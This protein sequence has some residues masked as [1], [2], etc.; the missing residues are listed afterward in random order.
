MKV[1]DALDAALSTL[2]EKPAAVLPA[3]F[4]GYGA[5][6]VARTIPLVG[7]FVAYLL[8]LVQGRLAP[9]EAA[10]R[11][12][13]VEALEGTDP[14]SVDPE[15]LPTEQL[16]QAVSGLLTPGVVAVLGL[17]VLLGLVVWLVVG[18]AFHAGRIHTVH[19]ALRNR[20]PVRA[21]VSGAIRDVKPFVGLRLLEYGLYLL[22]TVVYGLVVF[23]AGAVYGADPGVGLVVAV[24]AAL[25]APLWLLALVAIAVV[26]VFA[27]QAV[28]VDRVGSI[29][30]LKRG[31]G[32][33]RRRPG[34][35]VVYVVIALG[36]ASAVTGVAAA[37]SALGVSQLGA[38]LSLLVVTPFLQLLKT[39]IYADRERI[40]AS[41][42][43]SGSDEGPGVGTRLRSGWNRSLGSLRSFALSGTGL[44]LTGVGLALFGLGTVGGYLA[45]GGF[46]IQTGPI[47][48]PTTVFGAFPVGTFT[49]IAANNWLV[50]LGQSFAGLAFGIPTAVN[51]LFNGAV[52][53][54]VA[55]ISADLP[56]VAALIV[57]HGLIE[58][59]AL[60][61]SGAVGFRLGHVSW[62]RARGGIDDDAVARELRFAFWVL[63]GL[64]AV[65]VL[66]SFVEAFLTPRIAG[67]M[68]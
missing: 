28:V 44:A 33:V 68:L 61:V 50:A 27:P 57:P 37:L 9:L 1:T 20:R 30:G 23:V 17:S 2:V 67:W 43:L 10:F 19:A 15:A 65:F 8:L 62:R 38:V 35:F 59:P 51:L 11:S 53:G 63:C 7:L 12:I 48:D 49:T 32:F 34:A 47:E 5:G 36:V 54:L 16:D 52:V 22:V 39:A 29:A 40:E 4:A 21:G 58:V 55:G 25:L 26:F 24:G 41:P 42:L 18:A 45:V 64:A 13:D 46:T 14:E 66:A 56:S 31:A 6:T 3:Y 60:A